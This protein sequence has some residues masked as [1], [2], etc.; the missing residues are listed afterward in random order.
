LKFADGEV[1]KTTQGSSIQP[2]VPTSRCLSIASKPQLPVLGNSS[3]QDQP[4]LLSGK[5]VRFVEGLKLRTI[6]ALALAARLAWIL[7]CP[8]EPTSDQSIYFGVAARMARGLGYV[9]EGGG[10][11]N[12]WPVGYP[13]LLAPAFAVLGERYWVAFLVNLVL[14]LVLVWGVYATTRV[15]AGKPAAAI[16]ATGVALH[17]TLVLYTT[18][19]ASEN[20]FM[21]G[22][23]W[24]F[25]LMLR[26]IGVGSDKAGPGRIGWL[27][28][29]GG[30]AGATLQIR[31]TA[32]LTFMAL[33][34]GFLLWRR[35]PGLTIAR[36]A[37]FASV[38]LAVTAPW[39]LRNLREFGRYSPLS[40]NGSAN[41]WMGNHEGTTGGYAELPREVS[42]MGLLEREDYLGREAWR[43]LRD[44]PGR[45]PLLA[46]RRTLE[47]LRSDTI[48]V[49]WNEIG[50]HRR[51]GKWAMLPLRLV[52]TG[53][54]WLILMAS[55]AIG[56][57]LLRT[58]FRR[59][60]TAPE[61]SK[62]S[63]RD[64]LQAAGLF[65]TQNAGE[66]MLFAILFAL[67]F[68][69]VFMVSGNRYHIPAIPFVLSLI[70]VRLS[71]Q[72]HA[73]VG[74]KEGA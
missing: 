55:A 56:L 4:S 7:L 21:P 20:A 71:R 1:G 34:L 24:T 6:L 14:G 66:M 69:F 41:M 74:P 42:T 47:T 35:R 18:C 11:F 40:F 36:L 57:H 64:S 10:A 61:T 63:I 54:H 38:V 30:V 48:G 60:R 59:V 29:L 52:T 37:V 72:R 8:N 26:S 33:P 65:F 15:L 62:G 44:H 45:I 12:Y 19:I 43:F 50:I 5:A 73:A 46:L 23:V 13:A 17:P 53:V 68:P 27:L 9:D 70:A 58:L 67:A 2:K 28:A 49:V 25:A 32:I 31:G 51:F 39:S 16:A 22:V 3:M